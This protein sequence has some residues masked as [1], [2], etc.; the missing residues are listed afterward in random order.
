MEVDRSIQLRFER[1]SPRVVLG[2]ACGLALRRQGHGEQVMRLGVVW[3]QTQNLLQLRRTF[4]E[5]VSPQEC[6]GQTEPDFRA[7]V[8]RFRAVDGITQSRRQVLDGL[9]RLSKLQQG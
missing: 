7:L 8:L 9:V 6:L 3:G 5:L 1:Q 2:W 4:G